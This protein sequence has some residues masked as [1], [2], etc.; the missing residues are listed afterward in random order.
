MRKKNYSNREHFSF[1]NSFDDLRDYIDVEFPLLPPDSK[2]LNNKGYSSGNYWAEKGGRYEEGADFIFGDAQK[3]PFDQLNSATMTE[4]INP[5]DLSEIVAN[6]KALFATIDLGGSFEKDRLIPTTQPTGIFS[7]DLASQGLYKPMEYYSKTLDSLVDPN[8]VEKLKSGEFV[9][10]RKI[11]GGESKTY[12]VVQQQAGTFCLSQKKTYIERLIKDGYSAHEAKLKAAIKFPNCKLRF[13]TRTRKVY[14]ERSGRTL[15][16]ERQGQQRYVDVFIPIGGSYKLSSKQLMYATLPALLAT[17]FFDQAGIQTRINGLTKGFSSTTIESPKRYM[18]SY[19]I[20]D[21]D[22]PF[23]FNR[24]AIQSADSRVFRFMLFKLVPI[25]FNKVNQNI[26]VSMGF[27]TS[28]ERLLKQFERYKRF[29]IKQ[30]EKTTIK[31]NNP[32][33]MITSNFVPSPKLSDKVNLE[34]A[35]ESF[36]EIIDAVDLEYNGA[37]VA[38]PRIRQREMNRKS[39]MNNIRQRL[40]G[41]IANSTVIDYTDSPYSMT[42]LE[43]DSTNALRSSL[44]RDLNAVF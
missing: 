10:V 40:N 25:L 35:I 44:R 8:T 6:I 41:V 24:I 9:S 37:K 4:F 2:V 28:G 26:G 30:A 5:K 27:D 12:Y 15:E 17:Y 3:I 36:F 11:G 13:A 29:Y 1:F 34:N 42:D 33:L 16:S 18:T 19:V 38:L 20:K 7:F 43:I 39:N 23:D 14:L 31:N 21:Y 22:Q 32:R